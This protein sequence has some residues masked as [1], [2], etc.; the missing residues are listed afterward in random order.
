[1]HRSWL[2]LALIAWPVAIR[3]QEDDDERK[4]TSRQEILQR[5][6]EK[7]AENLE[8]YEVSDTEKR[9]RGWEKAKFPQNWLVKGWRGFRPVIGGM[10]SG[11]GTVIGGGYIHGLENQYFQFQAN[12]RWST[13]GYKT[14]DAEVVLPP[15]QLGRRTEFK[16][17]AEYR[18]LTALSFFGIGNDSSLEN[19]SSFLLN[20]QSAMAY[21]WLNPIGCLLVVIIAFIL[22]FSEDKLLKNR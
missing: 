21:L 5:E 1:M 11:S 9:L 16:A 4:P 17:R 20:D 19:E 3:A 10:P 13:K 22:Q 18:D 2:V 12:G 14:A 15:P 7:K 8:P 6:R